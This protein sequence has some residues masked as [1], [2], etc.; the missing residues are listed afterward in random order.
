MKCL[1][2]VDL[3]QGLVTP[4]CKTI[5][6]NV[7]KLIEHFYAN[8]DRVVFTKFHHTDNSAYPTYLGW[9][10]LQAP[11]QQALLPDI[12]RYARRIFVKYGYG[13]W[14]GAMTH[15]IKAH[16]IKQLYLVGVDTD[17]CIYHSAL[18]TFDRQIQPIV[19]A[20][21]CMSGAGHDNHL[22]ALKLLKRHVGDANIVS[23]DDV[24]N[25]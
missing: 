6:P 25:R 24:I 1:C 20:D 3:Q 11:S 2:V 14:T 18:Q 7:V 16:H 5:I 22:A 23:L 10:K 9:D 17:A 4:E 12:A 21:A 8:H 15:Y 19:V 13:M